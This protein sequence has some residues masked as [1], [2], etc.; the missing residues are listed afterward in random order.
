MTKK[1]AGIFQ[2]QARET[3]DFLVSMGPKLD[4]IADTAA[5]A[6]PLTPIAAPTGVAVDTNWDAVNRRVIFR[7][8]GGD[9]Y[10]SYHLETMFQTTKG[11]LLEVDILVVIV[12]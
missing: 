11:Q 1:L 6:G 10:K 4:A 2:K 9:V 7:V 3:R 12:G 5:V 8:S